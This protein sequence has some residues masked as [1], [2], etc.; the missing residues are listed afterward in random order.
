MPRILKSYW[1]ESFLNCVK[2]HTESPD[3]FMTW[4]A[5]SVLGA[6]MKRKFYIKDGLYDIYPNQYIVL[7]SPPGIGKGTAVQFAWSL[8]RQTTNGSLMANIISD[9][10]TSPRIIQRIADGWNSPPSMVG[11]QLVLGA[12]DHS[13][14]IYSTELSILV[15]A[16]DM[17][18]DFLCESWDRGE[19]D[20]DT[21]NSGSAFIKDMC[22]SLIGCTVPDFIR[23][24]DRNKNMSIKGGFTSRCLFIY[25]DVPARSLLHPQPIAHN[26]Q[27]KKLLDILRN[28]L[29]YISQLP[30][31]EYTYSTG[32]QSIFD[33]FML[34]IKA[35]Y[36]DDS[37]AVQ[38]FKSRIRAHVFK[39]AM[40]TAISRHDALVID[41][42]DMANAICQVQKALDTIELVFGGSGDSDLAIATGYVQ[43]YVEK[44]GIASQRD[45]LRNLYRH[46]NADTL[47]RVLYVLTEIGYFVTDT[48]GKQVVYKRALQSPNGRVKP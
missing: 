19:Y 22:T 46:M 29:L 4:A 11:Q 3:R 41:T 45:M 16:S 36:K 26:P 9:R 17:M 48:V 5:Y 27:S 14:T 23:N 28:D 44:V 20:Y 25:E 39:L 31:G 40:V 12:K 15:G 42:C 37:D 24:I 35:N 21:K 7:V 10:V 34:G 13:C 2:P 33:K 8:V 38:H 43:S 30:G 32:A 47:T 18:L 1:Y 6:V